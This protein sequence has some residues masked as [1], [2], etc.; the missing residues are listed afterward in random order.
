MELDRAGLRVLRFLAGA[1]ARVQAAASP[2]MLLLDGGD[3]GAMAVEAGV[4]AVLERQALAARAGGALRLTV[5]GRAALDEAR[6]RRKQPFL[7]SARELGDATMQTGG[8]YETLTVNHAESPLALLRRRRAKDGR[9][10]LDEREFRA[11]ERLRA[12]YTR[13]QIMPRL[14][15]NWDRAGAAGRGRGE[16][17]GIAEL[18]EAAMAARRRVERAIE[19]VGPELSG[20]LIDVCCFLKGVE[21]VETE[22]GWPARSAKVVL[23][24]ALGVLARHYEPVREGAGKGMRPAILHWGA[25][26][27]RPSLERR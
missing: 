7:A 4:L 5:A 16:A 19:A 27:F 9:F 6:T 21:L 26:D 18:T 2:A 10:F 12:D 1:P 8:G 23:K 24:T 15:V 3:K 14:G 20:V 25:Q 13:G 22:R 11:G 17:G